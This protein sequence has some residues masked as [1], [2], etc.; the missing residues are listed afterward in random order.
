VGIPG[1]SCILSIIILLKKAMSHTETLRKAHEAF[2]AHRLDEA[3][4]LVAPVTNVV[5]HRRGQTMNTREAFRGWMEAFF[6]MASD[7]RLVN[8]R[9]LDAGEWV[10]AQFQAVGTQDGPIGAFAATNRP[11]TLDVCEVW[12]FNADGQAVEGHNYSDGLGLLMQLGHL[13]APAEMD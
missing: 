13:A 10:T 12:R 9:Y 2:S 11:F 6:S 3:V 5:D 1:L 7:I 8:A 4:Q